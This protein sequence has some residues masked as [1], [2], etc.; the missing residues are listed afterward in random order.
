LS[1]R[2]MLDYGAPGKETT[3]IMSKL[4]LFWRFRLMMMAETLNMT[5]RALKADRPSLAMNIVRTNIEMQKEME[6]WLY[7]DDSIHSRMFLPFRESWIDNANAVKMAGPM[8]PV[9][10]AYETMMAFASF[11]AKATLGHVDRKE[12]VKMI[13]N[14]QYRPVVN[15]MLE[16]V[17]PYDESKVP[18]DYITLFKALNMW[19]WAKEYF[20]IEERPKSKAYYSSPVYGEKGVQ[21]QFAAGSSGKMDLVWWQF[22]A[23]LAGQQRA[24][25]EY[26]TLSMAMRDDNAEARYRSYGDLNPLLYMLSEAKV[27]LMKPGPVGKQAT[28]RFIHDMRVM[29]E[30]YEKNIKKQQGIE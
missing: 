14:G 25:R 19:P 9:A 17:D 26:S 29:K 30:K 3:G 18:D 10:E 12:V 8:L 24:M 28:M 23:L 20:Q 6:T 27:P 2:S 5:G 16:H 7:S 1:R 4:T 11:T 15:L 13:A 21:Y 22:A